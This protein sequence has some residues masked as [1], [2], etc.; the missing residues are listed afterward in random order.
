MCVFS[1]IVLLVIRSTILDRWEDL[2]SPVMIK[3][4]IEALP[5]LELEHGHG[6][7]DHC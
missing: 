3:S 4:P 5:Q 6:G 1:K 2:S 7:P